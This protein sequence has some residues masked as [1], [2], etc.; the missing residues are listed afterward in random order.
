MK[1]DG[2]R[3]DGGRTRIITVSASS[4][5]AGKSTVA[6]HLVRELGADYGLKVSSGGSLAG[7][8]LTSDRD[9]I[10][11]HGTD[12]GAL[13]EAGAGK[14]LWVNAEGERLAR[15]LERALSMFPRGGLLVLEGNSALEYVE[16]DFAIFVMS[17]PFDEFKPSAALALEKSDLVLVNRAGKLGSLEKA[18]LERSL[19][20]RAPGAEVMFFDERDASLGEI[21][22]EAVR[23]VSERLAR[24]D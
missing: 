11:R 16:P 23:L 1:S 15:E 4:K 6:A 10:S 3:P 9:E 7:Q 2:A 14:V 21:L 18:G 20:E 22:D 17:V 5:K 8:P 19:R 24:C 12:T 13:V